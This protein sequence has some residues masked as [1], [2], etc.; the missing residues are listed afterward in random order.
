[1]LLDLAI[2]LVPIVEEGQAVVVGLGQELDAAGLGEAPEAV[3]NLGCVALELLERDA[4]DRERHPE[5]GDQTLSGRVA[6]EAAARVLSLLYAAP[7]T[8]P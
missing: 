3:E 5:A 1:M 8:R 2:E 6:A 4:R 7:R